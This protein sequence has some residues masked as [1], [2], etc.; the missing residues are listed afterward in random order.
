[1]AY[2]STNVT[3]S[4]AQYYTG[5]GVVALALWVSYKAAR[6]SAWLRIPAVAFWIASLVL[7]AA[8]NVGMLMGP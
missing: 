2:T 7:L 4:E 1:M 6:A 5:L 8:K 3:I